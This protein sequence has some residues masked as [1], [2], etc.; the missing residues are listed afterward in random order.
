MNGWS[1]FYV[2]H[3]FLFFPTAKAQGEH[4]VDILCLC[5]A[6]TDT[7]IISGLTPDRKEAANE[8]IQARVDKVLFSMR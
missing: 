5:P 6:W 7:E 1:L 4:D 3:I 2:F 8:Q